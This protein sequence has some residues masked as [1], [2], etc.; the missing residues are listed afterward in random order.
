MKIL[1]PVNIQEPII[2][3][4][5]KVANLHVFIINKLYLTLSR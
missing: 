3:K 1:P 5:Q 4:S 2:P